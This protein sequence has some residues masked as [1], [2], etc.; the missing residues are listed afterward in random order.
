MNKQLIAY[1]S[2]PVWLRMP[3]V[4][5]LG[6]KTNQIDRSPNRAL[7]HDIKHNSFPIFLFFK[8]GWMFDF[9]IYR[10]NSLHPSSQ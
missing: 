6:I 3:S 10:T 7:Q 9:L 2:Y 5:V 1:N 8:A 4:K